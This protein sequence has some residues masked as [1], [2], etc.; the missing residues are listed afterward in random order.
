[1]TP[2]ATA[3]TRMPRDA[4]SVASE[5]VTATSPPLVSEVVEELPKA[6][7]V[8][9]IEGDGAA[10]ADLVTRATQALLVAAGEDDLGPP[11]LAPVAPF[12]ARCRRCR[13]SRRPS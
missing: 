2:R 6:I 5:R 10:R 8:G 7:R 11:R 9:R 12:R 13:R 1:M 4:Y 3:L